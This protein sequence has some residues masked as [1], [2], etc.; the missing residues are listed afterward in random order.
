M[1]LL[2]IVDNPYAWGVLGFV[3]G[4]ALGVTAVSVWLV[5]IGLAGFVVYLRVHGPADGATEGTLIAAGPVFILGWILGFMVRGW[6]T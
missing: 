5:V 4:A 3:I 6:I 2:R 1:T